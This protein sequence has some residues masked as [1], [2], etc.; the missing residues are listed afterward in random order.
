MLYL[1]LESVLMHP[2]P[3]P[4]GLRGPSG[5]D[6]F[7]RIAQRGT[8]FTA[9]GGRAFMRLPAQSF[10]GF[11]TLP[12][13]SRPFR[14]WFFHQSFFTYDTLRTRKNP[15]RPRQPQRPVRRNHP[16]RLAR[17]LRRRRPLRNLPRHLLP[18]RPRTV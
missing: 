12:I 6:A 10:G 17:E 11:R 3:K 2:S 16:Q 9:V 7:L 15:P 8:P 14:Q 5:F 18:T 1:E 4:R 13:R